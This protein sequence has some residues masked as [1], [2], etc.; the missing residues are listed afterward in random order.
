MGS[1]CCDTGSPFGILIDSFAVSLPREALSSGTIAIF[2]SFERHCLLGLRRHIAVLWDDAIAEDLSSHIERYRCSDSC[3]NRREIRPIWSWRSCTKE[4]KSQSTR[5]RIVKRSPRLL[6]AEGHDESKD[7]QVVIVLRSFHK[8]NR[9]G[10][11]VARGCRQK[12]Q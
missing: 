2:R 4:A 8:K 9:W 10:L 1:G 5:L 7:S 11:V 6:L 3:D 12:E